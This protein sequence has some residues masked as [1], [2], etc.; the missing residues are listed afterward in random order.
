M[1][2]NSYVDLSIGANEKKYFKFTA[3]RTGFYRFYTSSYQQDGTISDTVVRL[4]SDENLTNELAYS[5]DMIVVTIHVKYSITCTTTT[6]TPVI[7][8]INLIAS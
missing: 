6:V 3:P 7:I 1:Q 8:S 4:Y 2:D 5:D